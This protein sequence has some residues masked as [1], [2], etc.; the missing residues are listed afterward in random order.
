MSYYRFRVRRAR[1]A[2]YIRAA[3]NFAL[4]RRVGERVAEKVARSLPATTTLAV[5]PRRHPRTEAVR[6]AR[7]CTWAAN[8]DFLRFANEADLLPS[9]AGQKNGAASPR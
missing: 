4:P 2:R 7:A 6:T 8:S 9:A 5:S 1:G 3:S